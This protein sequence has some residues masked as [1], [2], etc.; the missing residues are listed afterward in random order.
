[1]YSALF[2]TTRIKSSFAV[3]MLTNYPF[4]QRVVQA[5]SFCVTICTATY[6]LF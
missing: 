2:Q 6:L 3:I 5:D 4:D 1:M